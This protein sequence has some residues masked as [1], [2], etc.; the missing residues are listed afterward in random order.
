MNETELIEYLQD[1][2][3]ATDN[4]LLECRGELEDANDKLTEIKEIVNDSKND[5]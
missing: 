4:E 5:S 2:L 1:E 3:D